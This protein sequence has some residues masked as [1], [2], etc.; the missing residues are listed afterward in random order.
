MWDFALE[1]CVILW[2]N[3]YADDFIES[4]VFYYCGNARRCLGHHP[5]A[6][7]FFYAKWRAVNVLHFLQTSNVAPIYNQTGDTF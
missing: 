2:Y 4:S 5:N 6:G 1:F 3:N 7:D